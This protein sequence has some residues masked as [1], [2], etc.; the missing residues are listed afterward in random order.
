M[1]SHLHIQSQEVHGLLLKQRNK[2]KAQLFL[3]FNIKSA[4]FKT[5]SGQHKVPSW[6]FFDTHANRA[7]KHSCSSKNKNQRALKS[8]DSSISCSSL[9]YSGYFWAISTTLSP[10]YIRLG[11]LTWPAISSASFSQCVRFLKTTFFIFTFRHNP[12]VYRLPGIQFVPQKC[13]VRFW[14]WSVGEMGLSASWKKTSDW[15]AIA[16]RIILVNLNSYE[17]KRFQRKEID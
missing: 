6:V 5:K 14:T 4:N 2:Q 9:C 8:R 11:Q 13:P 17:G 1:L 3:L 16:A 7:G 12:A 15:L 10:C